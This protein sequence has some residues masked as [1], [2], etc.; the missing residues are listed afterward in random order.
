MSFE[1]HLSEAL[2]ALKENILSQIKVS[3]PGQ[4][5]SYDFATQKASVKPLVGTRFLDGQD[6]PMPVIDGV[7]VVWPSSGGASLTMPVRRGDTVELIF[8]GKS[9]DRWLAQGGEVIPDD[10]R[11]H[12]ISDCVAIPG[13]KSFAQGGMAT[14]NDSVLLVYNNS[15]IKISDSGDIEINA[16]GNVR[17]TGQ[18]IDLN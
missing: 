18:R 8:S 12:N 9:L 2:R 11:K 5:E 15:F 13:L 6:L 1:R 14:D 10:N 7:P 17:I 4:I 3:L 16:S